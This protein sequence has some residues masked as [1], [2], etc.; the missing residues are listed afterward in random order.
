[1]R[2]TLARHRRGCE[3]EM[4]TL[5]HVL[6]GGIRDAEGEIDACRAAIG[7]MQKEVWAAQDVVEAKEEREAQVL[8][9]LSR[10]DGELGVMARARADAEELAS[11]TATRLT[12]EKSARKK[13]QVLAQQEIDKL[14]SQANALKKQVDEL[15]SAGTAA[16]RRLQS[17]ELEGGSVRA[18]AASA[19]E[20][21]GKLEAKN[22]ELNETI[23]ARDFELR[24]RD[25]HIADLEAQLKVSKAEAQECNELRK[26]V[27]ELQTVLRDAMK[28]GTWQ[29]CR[30]I[31]YHESLRYVSTAAT[32]GRSTSSGAYGA[33][34][35]VT[36]GSSVTRGV[37]PP[38]QGRGGSPPATHGRGSPPVTQGRGSPPPMLATL[39]QPSHA[40]SQDA[41][42]Q[43]V[44]RTPQPMT[45][46][47]SSG[48]SGIRRG[49]S[50]TGNRIKELASSTRALAAASHA[51]LNAPSDV[52]VDAPE[53]A[54]VAVAVA[55]ARGPNDGDDDTPPVVP[56]VNE[57]HA[58]E[59]AAGEAVLAGFKQ[60][61]VDADAALAA[62]R[63]EQPT[64][65]PRT[66]GG[67]VD[68]DD[69]E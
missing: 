24:E 31:L 56:T 40:G 30:Q 66:E 65:E 48:G 4:A 8:L 9:E 28:A 36:R 52:P 49:M 19:V 16:A 63:D 37:S 46:G 11:E 20:K 54:A 5:S 68:D 51:A 12:A 18:L 2:E 41:S 26:I 62:A 44:R 14:T 38:T 34:P 15:D 47:S 25:Q 27:A 23:N 39:S 55:A 21:L 13:D 61:I 58:E 64:T 3:G 43:A 42:W 17:A 6:L 10:K 22:A 29:H 32:H 67:G 59:A 33:A 1:M 53:A 50:E 7:S 45:R 35:S 57:L 60:T 69:A